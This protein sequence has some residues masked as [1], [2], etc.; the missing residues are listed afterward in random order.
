MHWRGVAV[1][2]SSFALA[3]RLIELEFPTRHVRA[4]EISHIIAESDMAADIHEAAAITWTGISLAATN[5]YLL[6]TG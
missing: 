4:I 6:G 5:G 3:V 1:L 2:G